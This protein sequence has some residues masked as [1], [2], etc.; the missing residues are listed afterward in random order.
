M[1]LLLIQAAHEQSTTDIA[2][3]SKMPQKFESCDG[4][5]LTAAKQSRVRAWIHLLQ[6]Q[7][8]AELEVCLLQL[9]L[10]PQAALAGLQGTSE[11]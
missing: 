2:V 4:L 6:E 5:W 9:P 7:L 10:T 11:A 8:Q 3:Q 1:L